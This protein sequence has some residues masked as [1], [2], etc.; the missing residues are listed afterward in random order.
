M[1][2]NFIMAILR[3]GEEFK[4]IVLG[5]HR[6]KLPTLAKLDDGCFHGPDEALVRKVVP[7]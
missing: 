2:H 5:D 3:G 1:K 6:P 7:P 4:A